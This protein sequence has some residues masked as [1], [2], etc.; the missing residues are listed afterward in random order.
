MIIKNHSMIFNLFQ[1][2]DGPEGEQRYSTTL[3]W[4][5]VLNGGGWPSPRPGRFTSWKEP[6][7]PSNR[8]LGGFS[9]RSGQVRK[10]SLPPGFDHRTLQS[11]A[12]RYTGWTIPTHESLGN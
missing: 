7:Y 8:R 12:N 9:G 5:S 6:R 4:T 10:I 2:H 3:S 11:V 1:G